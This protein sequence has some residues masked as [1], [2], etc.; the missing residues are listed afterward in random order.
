MVVEEVENQRPQQEKGQ[1]QQGEE[2]KKGDSP[3]KVRR[4]SAKLGEGNIK[5]EGLICPT[6]KGVFETVDELLEHSAQ[7]TWCSSVNSL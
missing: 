7:C 3:E 2:K 1:Q 6:C 4:K 5:S